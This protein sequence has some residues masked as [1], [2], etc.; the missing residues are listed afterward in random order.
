MAGA[1]S[2]AASISSAKVAARANR[3]RWRPSEAHCTAAA[4]VSGGSP[5]AM[6]PSR[7][8]RIATMSSVVATG[9]RTNISD[10]FTACA[11][12]GGSSC[13]SSRIS[14][15]VAPR[16]VNGMPAH[17]PAASTAVTPGTIANGMPSLANRHASSLPFP[18]TN[19][20][21]P[22]KRTTRFPARASASSNASISAGDRGG[23][24]TKCF[25][26]PGRHHAN[27]PGCTPG[28]H[29]TASAVSISSRARTVT[30]SGSPGP[31]PTRCTKPWIMLKRKRPHSGR[32]GDLVLPARP[33]QSTFFPAS[34]H[35]GGQ[36]H[37]A[38]TP[39]GQIR[40]S[41]QS[42]FYGLPHTGPHRPQALTDSPP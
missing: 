40:N 36:P 3:L 33:M 30:K 39:A 25:S 26:Q 4:G 11:R 19:G 16:C 27:T 37:L 24:P 41:A 28:S 9:R 32:A 14:A 21:P 31:A 18:K 20:S 13:P 2:F 5:P 34:R 1:G 17:A 6:S 29:T 35:L 7:M 38:A 10:T 12:P 23:V 22:F 15:E 42:S 8:E